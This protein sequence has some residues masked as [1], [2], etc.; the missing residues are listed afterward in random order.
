MRG[1]ILIGFLCG[2]CGGF[3]PDDDCVDDPAANHHA[4][5][6]ATGECWEFASSCDVPPDWMPCGDQTQCDEERACPPNSICVEGRCEPVGTGCTSDADCPVTEHCDFSGTGGVGEAPI[7]G[8]CTPNA[9]CASDSDCPDGQ[10]C[11]FPSGDCDPSV[12]GCGGLSAGICTRGTGPGGTC[13]TNTDCGGLEICPIQWGGTTD[14]C[15]ASCMD[16]S[17]CAAD[18]YCNSFEVCAQPNPGDSPGPTPSDPAEPVPPACWGWCAQLAGQCDLTSD[19]ASGEICPA[20]YTGAAVATCVPACES[21]A[22]CPAGTHCTVEDGICGTEQPK[23][24]MRDAAG[25]PAF[26]PCQGWCQ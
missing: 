25:A 21:T 15:E 3:V 2:A 23:R 10:F 11:D 9:A 14:V 18:E 1:L 20:E 7:S 6:P 5:N 13:M 12:P 17:V 4:I 24:T 22:E 26:I 8:T 19:C 16:S